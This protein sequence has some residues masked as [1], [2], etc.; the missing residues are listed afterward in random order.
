MLLTANQLSAQAKQII[1]TFVSN[2]ANITYTNGSATD[3]QKINR[4]RGIIH[5]ITTSPDFAIQR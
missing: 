3:P 2:T 4:L 1:I 5:L